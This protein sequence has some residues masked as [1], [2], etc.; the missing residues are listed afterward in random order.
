MCSSKDNFDNAKNIWQWIYKYWLIDWQYVTGIYLH[1][2]DKKYF[3]AVYLVMQVN[4]KRAWHIL[5][6]STSTVSLR[7]LSL[8]V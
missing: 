8:E 4:L 3:Y 7:L 6:K 1:L 2:I 5:K